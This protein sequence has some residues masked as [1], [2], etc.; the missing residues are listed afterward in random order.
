M[1]EIMPVPRNLILLSYQQG[2][3]GGDLLQCSV[4]RA[5]CI[6]CSAGARRFMPQDSILLKNDFKTQKYR[7]L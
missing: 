6:Y 3:S 1:T 4:S 7:A 2:A 5:L